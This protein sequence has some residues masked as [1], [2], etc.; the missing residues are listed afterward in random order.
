MIDGL[1]DRL[2]NFLENKTYTWI[3]DKSNFN[4]NGFI[5]KIEDS[6]FL[7]LD[8]ELGEIPFNKEDIIFINFSRKKIEIKNG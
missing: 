8:D 5:K 1:N 2:N 7:F 4:F 3:I 6:K